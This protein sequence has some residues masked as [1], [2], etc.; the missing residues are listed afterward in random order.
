MLSI[1]S[2]LEKTKKT[3]RRVFVEVV[4]TST[5]INGR[6]LYVNDKLTFHDIDRY[7]YCYMIVKYLFH[8]S[9]SLNVNTNYN[10]F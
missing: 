2:A 7:I 10:Y 6:K 5:E 4:T 3:R 1:A 9:L 8:F